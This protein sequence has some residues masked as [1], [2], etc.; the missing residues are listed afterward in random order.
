MGV[1][2]A[3][4]ISNEALSMGEIKELAAAVETYGRVT[5]LVPSFEARAAACASL[6]DAGCGLGVDVLTPQ[7]WISSLWE[8]FGDG[9]RLIDSL[10]R[11]MLMGDALHAAEREGSLAP[12][13]NNPG[14]LHMLGDMARD[15]LGHLVVALDETSAQN[16]TRRR[17]LDVLE[18]YGCKIE[19]IGLAE[20]SQAAVVLAATLREE[21]P[22]CA[23]SLFVRDAAALPGYLIDL[24][25]AVAASGEVCIWL[26]PSFFPDA[27]KLARRFERD[28]CSCSVEVPA[29]AAAPWDRRVSSLG[30]LEVSGPHARGRAY[31][32]GLMRLV[33]DDATRKIGVVCQ[34]PAA[35]FRDLADRLVALGCSAEV[36]YR[37]GF[38]QT[39]TGRQ[40]KALADV[41]ARMK[42]QQ[43]GCA[44]KTEWWP[45]P[46]LTDWLYSPLS[47]VDA[48][49]ARGF[50][51][52]MR[53]RR[54]M[55]AELVLREL[56][57][58]QARQRSAR[59][60][61][62]SDHPL[63]SIPVVCAD[64]VQFLWQGR[65]VSALK[66]MLSVCEA[67][68][69]SAW[70]TAGLCQANAERAAASAAVDALM[71]VAREL[72]VA[73]TVAAEVLDALSVSVRAAA[74][75]SRAVTVMG[76]DDASC[77]VEAFSD[78][79]QMRFLTL[80]QA[81][82]A[83]QGSFDALFFA[84][85]DTQS[86]SLAHEESAPAALARSLGC[87]GVAF[88]PAALL[89][90]RVRRALGV[91][92]FHAT[93]ARVTHDCQAKDRYP[94]AVWTS[95]VAAAKENLRLRTAGESEIVEDLDV[96]AARGLRA[97]RVLCLPAQVLSA[98]AVPYVVLKRPF[99]G[100]SASGADVSDSA[101]MRALVPRQFSASQIEA[102]SS[103]P[104]CWFVSSR[105]RPQRIDAG[106]G[107]M[108]KG[109]FVHDVMERLHETL[110]ERG[111]A[112]VRPETLAASLDVLRE[113]FA[114]VR[115]EHARGKT[116]SSAPL[117]AHSSVEEVQIDEILDQLEGVVRYEAGALAAFSPEYLEYSFNDL[118]VVYAGWPLGGRID[119]VDVD[120]EG[121]AVVIDYKHR[122]DVSG[123]RLKDPTVAAK[124]GVVAADDPH[125]LP[126]HTQSLIY[127][128][129]L[130]RA[131]GL[132]VRG[133]LYFSTKGRAPAMRGAVS[134]ELAEEERGDG[135]VPGLK[136]G[137]PDET[138]GGSMT[139]EQLL[140]RVEDEIAQR[141]SRLAAG[142]VRAAEE[143]QARCAYNHAIG[144]ERRDA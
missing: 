6:A 99:D 65:P 122:S 14:T 73:Q 94:A 90:E 120:A 13:K 70:G 103:C 17:V 47:G 95:L 77:S 64:V 11:Q 30:F 76:N 23:R 126:T 10:R 22:A 39:A 104:L 20:A 34:R 100:G 98:Q 97:E 67:Q 137:F 102:Y 87:E 21:R 35:C 131:L 111:I 48:S 125:W 31:V 138:S 32:D 139:F 18:G 27:A 41:V 29:S 93:F 89:E 58:V 28:G 78:V 5:L 56:Q 55:D 37:V 140:D 24:L 121:R 134:A 51:K 59:K 66:A 72:D 61:L 60:K 25:G 96:A 8:L 7:A 144:F 118:D 112:R 141:L 16:A 135:R 74:T 57:S 43:D 53:S 128:Q 3:Q 114:C 143:P 69:S 119:R 127:A 71:T 130:R 92:G 42:A 124:N 38:A 63:S 107:N 52:K 62:A 117:I 86:Y 33:Q 50:D 81:S 75:P 123:Y 40:F 105:V 1:R 84:D 49:L 85:M 83:G 9:R 116:S 36:S 142:D 91:V 136:N 115:D 82:F 15:L 4:D 108:E 109:N 19:R 2:I 80:E 45:A 68:P 101:G 129:A 54:D 12:L 46:E 44:S 106:F 26:R 133:A 113:V 132:D 79:P 88:E 110:K